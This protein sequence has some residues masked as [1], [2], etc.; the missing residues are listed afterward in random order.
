MYRICGEQCRTN[1]I[2]DCIISNGQFCLK[3]MEEKQGLP[4]M[5]VFL[6]VPLEKRMKNVSPGS[7]EVPP[8]KF[9]YMSP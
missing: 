3:N 5:A 7:I 4:K 9:E 1:V 8:E 6:F 2:Q